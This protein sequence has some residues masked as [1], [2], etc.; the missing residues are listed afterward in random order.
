MSTSGGK[1]GAAQ[2]DAALPAGPTGWTLIPA[3]TDLESGGTARLMEIPLSM[4]SG[5][6]T[7]FQC[8]FTGDAFPR[9]IMI[10]DG[11]LYTGDGTFNPLSSGPGS[12]FVGMIPVGSGGFQIASKNAEL[13]LTAAGVVILQS[14]TTLLLSAGTGPISMSSTGIATTPTDSHTATVAYG[15]LAVGTPLQNGLGYD[16]MVTGTVNVTAA[17]AGSLKLGVG[18]TATPTTDPIT[19]SITTAAL[20]VVAF[21]AIVPAGYYLSLQSAGTITLA[22][23]V[24]V[25]TPL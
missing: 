15:A 16:I 23:P 4:D 21:S 11:S 22:S 5:Y 14:G 19:G 1:T 13:S 24:I 8:R 7:V 18:P 2:V 6:V 17:T 3:A 10:S 25:V 20:S 9:F 12:G